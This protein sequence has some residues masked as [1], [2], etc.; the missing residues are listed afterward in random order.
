MSTK[1][2]L[3]LLLQIV[4]S[5]AQV[6]R[7]RLLSANLRLEHLA[8]MFEA[9]FLHLGRRQPGMLGLLKV[10]FGL[11]KELVALRLCCLDLFPKLSNHGRLALHLC[12]QLCTVSNGAIDLLHQIGVLRCCHSFQFLFA[13]TQG[14]TKLCHSTSCRRR[15][16]VLCRI[17]SLLKRGQSACARRDDLFRD[18]AI[19]HE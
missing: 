1:C 12:L 16:S 8:A 19:C 3:Q 5:N 9:V 13:L 10:F 18:L 7:C 17:E 14:L 15:A 11:L 2:T 4:N 6:D